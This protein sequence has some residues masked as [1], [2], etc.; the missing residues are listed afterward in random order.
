MIILLGFC[1]KLFFKLHDNKIPN[2][3]ISLSSSLSI[4]GCSP[5]LK[6]NVLPILS[7]KDRTE[8]LRNTHR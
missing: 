1:Y 5:D 2:F 3:R 4:S 7:S 6:N 8:T